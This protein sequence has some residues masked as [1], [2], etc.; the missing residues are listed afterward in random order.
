MRLLAPDGGT[1]TRGIEAAF[2]VAAEAAFGFDLAR[3]RK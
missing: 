2:H 3:R 1:L